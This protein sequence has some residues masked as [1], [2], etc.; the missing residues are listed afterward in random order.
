MKVLDVLKDAWEKRR[1]VFPVTCRELAEALLRENSLNYEVVCGGSR[2]PGRCDWK[3]R[4]IYLS[5]ESENRCLAAVFQAAHEVG[6]AFHGPMPV[7]R[8]LSLFWGAYLVWLL[9]CLWGGLAWSEGT[10][11]LLL[12]VM[13]CLFGVRIVDSW[14]DELRATRYSRNQL[15]KLV[16]G[17]TEKRALQLHFAAYCLTHIVLPVSFSAA[18]LSGGRVF[19]CFGKLLGGSGIC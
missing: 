9:L 6:H 7:V 11:R 18:F 12:A 1:I 5:Y 10:W 2:V 19:W 15:K 14:F 4:T 17:D 8:A 3:R 16:V 13:A